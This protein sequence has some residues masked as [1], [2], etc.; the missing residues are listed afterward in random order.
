MASETKPS[1]DNHSLRRT[2]CL[3][4][5][6]LDG[7]NCSSMITWIRSRY[8]RWRIFSLVCRRI[9]SNNYSMICEDKM[10]FDL[11]CFV[12]GRR[13]ERILM[14]FR[15]FIYGLDRFE[16]S[17]HAFSGSTKHGFSQFPHAPC[18]YPSPSDF[19]L[20]FVF[21]GSFKQ[22]KVSVFHTSHRFTAVCLIKKS[23]NCW[24]ARE[25]RC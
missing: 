18:M 20:L 15:R 9:T 8:R 22:T 16:T 10:R 5:C 13:N 6:S 3:H 19:R 25:Q 1:I 17:S 7:L 23:R 11:D 12:N 14:L 24:L 2:D 4:C 21:S